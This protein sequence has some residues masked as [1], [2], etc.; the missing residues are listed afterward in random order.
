M[1]TASTYIL[2]QTEPRMKPQAGPNTNVENKIPER[3]NKGTEEKIT[4]L[5]QRLRHKTTKARKTNAFPLIA[6]QRAA[7]Y[8]ACEMFITSS[9]Y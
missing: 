7:L 2:V 5:F 8:Q 1:K 4:A 6:Q 3:Q 9:S